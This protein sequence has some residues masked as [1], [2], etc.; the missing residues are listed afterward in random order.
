MSAISEH[1]Y[2][3]RIVA[4]ERLNATLSAQIDRMNPVV[5]MA[6]QWWLRSKYG[7]ERYFSYEQ[8]LANAVAEY[9]RQMVEVKEGRR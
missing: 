3:Q 6:Q 1:E 9:E 2:Q 5:D 8:R 4:L 7:M